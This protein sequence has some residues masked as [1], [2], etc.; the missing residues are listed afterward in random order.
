MEQSP[1]EKEVTFAEQLLHFLSNL[2]WPEVPEDVEVMNPYADATAWALTQTFYRKYYSDNQARTLIIGIN[3]GRFGGGVTGI[4][5]TDP[6]KLQD[7]CGIENNLARKQELSSTFIYHM[8]AAFGGPEAFYKYFCFSAVSPVG[9]TMHGKNLN[10]YDHKELQTKQWVS[11]MT[12]CFESQLQ[13]GVNREVAYVLGQGQN[14]KF[15]SKLN[16]ENGFFEKLE[17]LPHPRW[18]MQYRLKRL[19]EFINVYIDKLSVHI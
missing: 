16:D 7:V 8:I 10:Y 1:G 11:F 13:M 6:F 15:L 14:L 18:V 2:E 12:S 9:F 17:V 4:P 5:F 3:P 19:E